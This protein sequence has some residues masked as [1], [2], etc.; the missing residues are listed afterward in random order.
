MIRVVIADDQA[1]VRGGFRLILG[2]DSEIEV[3]GEAANGRE[4]LELARGSAPDVVLMD[5]RMPTLDGIEATRRLVAANLG[6]RVL[7]LT[8]FDLDE[9]VYK[10]ISAGASGFLLKD[11]PPPDLI[12]AVKTVAAGEMLL[13]PTITRRLVEEFVRRPPPGR[14]PDAIADLTE[15]EREVLTLIARGLSNAEIAANLFLSETTVKTTSRGSSRSS[16][17]ATASRRSCSPTKRDW[18]GLAPTEQERRPRRRLERSVI[19][20]RFG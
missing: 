7:M 6:A 15:R 18:S 3:V 16:T 1:L 10:A 2:S 8:T 20:S 5:V 13:A 9:Y 4:A 12:Y 19:R 14:P 11:V 17:C